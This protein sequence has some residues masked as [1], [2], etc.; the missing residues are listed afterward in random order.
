MTHVLDFPRPLCTRIGRVG[1]LTER[2][3]DGRWQTDILGGP[4]DGEAFRWDSRAEAEQ[5][6]MHTVRLVRA[7][8]MAP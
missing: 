3:D 5:G 6:H 8:I 4:L 2:Q 7:C 1:V